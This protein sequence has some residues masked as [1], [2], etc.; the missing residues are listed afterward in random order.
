M[1]SI[2]ELIEKNNYTNISNLNRQKGFVAP[3]ILE[4]A[5]KIMPASK[6]PK[7]HKYEPQSEE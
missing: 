2:L 5:K 3:D 1:K 7:I 6:F 4:I